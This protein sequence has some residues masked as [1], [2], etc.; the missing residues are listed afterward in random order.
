MVTYLRDPHLE[1][2]DFKPES[3]PVWRMFVLRSAWLLVGG[4]RV[5]PAHDLW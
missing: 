4:T 3:D 1:V 2:P 5:H